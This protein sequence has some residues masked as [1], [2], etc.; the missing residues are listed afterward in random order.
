M[1]NMPEKFRNDEEIKQYNP[2]KEVALKYVDNERCLYDDNNK[3]YYPEDEQ[4][5]D[6]F[7]NK[8][9]D[10]TDRIITSIPAEPWWGNPL[11]AKLIILSLNPGYVP[12]INMTLAKLLQYTSSVRKSLI[13]YKK[14]TL[15]LKADSLIPPKGQMEP[16]SC[17][18]AVNMLGDWYWYKKLT[19]L[20]NDVNMD[21]DEF[22]KNVAIIEYHGYSS[23]TSDHNFPI[24]NK[25]LETQIFIKK[26]IWYLAE[27]K[28]DVRFLIVRSEKKWISLLCDG[29]ADFYEK[30]KNKFKCKGHKGMSQ[31]ITAKNLGEKIYGE[32]K[33]LFE[34]NVKK[35]LK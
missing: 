5:I 1:I 23:Q 32:L 33:E 14:L 29:Y 12:E 16:I 7:N 20:Q 31:S 4:A 9:G 26:M 11:K 3:Y 35:P 10:G 8:W 25:Y 28:K 17:R 30:Y 18:E 34:N 6:D 27:N 24:G 21:E 2:W 19:T 15:V 22:Y 13:D